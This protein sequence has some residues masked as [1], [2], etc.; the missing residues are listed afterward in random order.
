ML[1]VRSLLEGRRI[2]RS[3]ATKTM[4]FRNFFGFGAYRSV[5]TRQKTGLQQGPSMAASFASTT[6]TE[7]DGKRWLT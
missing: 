2:N 4:C 3:P 5:E 7:D 1:K 6:G